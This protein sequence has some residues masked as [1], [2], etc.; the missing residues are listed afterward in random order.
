[1]TQDYP[2]ELIREKISRR[3]TKPVAQRM[4]IHWEKGHIPLET[5]LTEG[6]VKKMGLY[7]HYDVKIF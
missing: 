5:I 1:M 3:Y 2:A 6:D 7:E 4:S